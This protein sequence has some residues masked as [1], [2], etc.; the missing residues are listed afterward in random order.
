MRNARGERRHRTAGPVPVVV[1]RRPSE[2]RRAEQKRGRAPG[3]GHRL[4]PQ[5]QLPRHVHHTRTPQVHQGFARQVAGH[6]ARGPLPGGGETPRPTVGP[7]R[8]VSGP[9]EVPVAP[10]YMGRRAKDPLFQRAHPESAPRVV[11]AGP[12]PEPH[13]KE[14]TGPGHRTDAHPGGQLVQ[15]PQATRSGGRGKKQVKTTSRFS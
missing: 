2:H 5:R 6:V 13:E 4:V 9:Q 10:D 1:A 15:K 7:G 3:P 11:P 14:G 8:Q 12:V